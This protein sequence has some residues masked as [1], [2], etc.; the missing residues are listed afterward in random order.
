MEQVR[1]ERMAAGK[2]LEEKDCAEKSSAAN[3]G[4]NDAEMADDSGAPNGDNKDAAA[5]VNMEEKDA[6]DKVVEDE[7]VPLRKKY[8]L[9][10]VAQRAEAEF[11]RRQSQPDGAP[12]DLISRPWSFPRGG[13]RHQVREERRE[14]LD[15][16]P[17]WQCF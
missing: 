9:D 4:S 11:Q 15:S 3:A 7:T 8:G 2:P 12:E 10:E 1:K 5:D 17:E 13:F 6:A 14:R 16:R